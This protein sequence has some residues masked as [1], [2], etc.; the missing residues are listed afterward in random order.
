MNIYSLYIYLQ[1]SILLFTLWLMR[2][3]APENAFTTLRGK[4]ENI[5]GIWKLR[6]DK[7]LLI[8]G[9]G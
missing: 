1:I 7:G 2:I 9:F 5:F 3:T 6:I 4:K 8:T